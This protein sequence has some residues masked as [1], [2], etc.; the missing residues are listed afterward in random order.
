MPNKI[1]T[2]KPDF[3]DADMTAHLKLLGRSA[4]SMTTGTLAI[5]S[6]DGIDIYRQKQ[7]VWCYHHTVIVS[8]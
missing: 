5:P 1:V 7:H 4:N 8:K 2:G 3:T 6:S